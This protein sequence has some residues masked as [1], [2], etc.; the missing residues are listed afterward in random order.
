M[1]SVEAGGSMQPP[2]VDPRP[3]DQERHAQRRVEVHALAHEA[4]VAQIVAVVGDE[5]HDRRVGEPARHELVEDAPD[6]VVQARRHAVV[7][8]AARP[9][10]GVVDARVVQRRRAR[11]AVG[12]GPFGAVDRVVPRRH[13][14][15]AVR[16]RRRHGGRVVRRI[17]RLRHREGVV[18]IGEADV[19]EERRVVVAGGLQHLDG[20][21]RDVLR[22]V[23]LGGQAKPV[24]AKLRRKLPAGRLPVSPAGGQIDA[25][26]GRAGLVVA[27]ETEVAVTVDQVRLRETEVPVA[28]F[29]GHGRR[30][31]IGLGSLRPQVD[32]ADRHAPVTG[33]LQHV[34][35]EARIV[36]RV[37]A[38]H[39]RLQH[40]RKAA[41]EQGGSTRRAGGLGD[42]AVGEP[43]AGSRQPI[44]MRRR[45]G[46]I[47]VAGQRV[48]AQLVGDDE[49]DVGHT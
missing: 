43:R 21:V 19:R 15:A 17:P 16:D 4:V 39:P 20:A 1:S 33:G 24:R 41:A 37:A 11:D 38:H 28:R 9:P 31:R 40:G 23:Q 32:L 10:G 13:V 27:A 26:I 14:G 3:P 12:F 25:E 30:Y 5:A 45:A 6:V 49:Q 36:G 7:R 8:G 42:D 35:Q 44:E 29:V 47:A 34:S 2:G 46:W 22:R 48:G 18:R